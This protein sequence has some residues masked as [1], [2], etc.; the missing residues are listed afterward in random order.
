MPGHTAPRLIFAVAAALLA[1]CSRAAPETARPPARSA[2]DLDYVL[3]GPRGATAYASPPAQPV[4]AIGTRLEHGFGFLAS[5]EKTVGGRRYVQLQDGRWL[6]AA[7]V[8]RVRPSTFA[9]AT[10]AP[11]ERLQ[12]AWVTAPTATVRATADA[13]A[14]ALGTRPYHAR[15]VLA[16][17]CTRGFCPLAAGWVRAS[18]LAVPTLAPRP[19]EV[20]PLEAWLDV[21]LASQTLVAYQGDEPRFA[22]LV[23][24]GIGLGDSP[25]ATPVGTFRVRSKHAVVRMDNLEHTGVEL[26]AYD[27]PLTQ[28]FKDGKALHAAPWHDQFGRARS[29]GCVNLSPRDATWLFAFTSPALAPGAPEITAT[30]AHPGT[31]VRVHG[32]LVAHAAL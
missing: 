23:S 28:Y 21:D 4:G 2:A 29:H 27:V 13:T 11:G 6:A 15:V 25:L 17:A 22:T 7:D 14:V 26:Y 31:V 32:Q 10:L 5:G 16:G 30:S 12:L 24:T 8:E 19:G 3:V 18:E 9:G 20:G 1:G